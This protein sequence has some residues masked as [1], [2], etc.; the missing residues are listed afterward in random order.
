MRAMVVMKTMMV[1]KVKKLDKKVV[2]MVSVALVI[3]V[4]NHRVRE[5]AKDNS[6]SGQKFERTRKV[7][8]QFVLCA[9]LRCLQNL[10]TSL[11]FS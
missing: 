3:L 8:E 6:N 4:V 5:I 7:Q 2:M 11:A 9:V 1:M 10:T